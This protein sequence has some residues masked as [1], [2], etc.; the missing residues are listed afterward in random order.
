LASC[1]E[2]PLA[3]SIFDGLEISGLAFT[4]SGKVAAGS[5]VLVSLSLNVDRR[6]PADWLVDLLWPAAS[7]PPP[8]S[9]RVLLPRLGVDCWPEERRAESFVHDHEQHQ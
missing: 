2:R 4:E 6:T 5:F 3:D 9:A 8:P 7:W 1:G